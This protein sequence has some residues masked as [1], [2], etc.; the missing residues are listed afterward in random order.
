MPQKME[1]SILATVDKIFDDA[2]SLCH[3]E[4][5]LKERIKACNLT[6]TIRF[7]VRLRGKV[8]SFNGWR[9]VHS[10]HQ[11]PA[12]GGIRYAPNV[13]QDEVEGLAALMTYKCALMGIPFSGSKG[14]LQ[15]DRTEW[16]P[17]ELERITR[18]FTQELAKRNLIGPSQNVPA[19]DM[20]T[21]ETEMAWIADEYQRLNRLDINAAACVTGKPLTHGGIEGRVEATGRGTQYAVQAFFRSWQDRGP[22][23]LEGPLKGK[24]VIIQ[25]LGNVGYHA[26]KFLSEE[27]GCIITGVIERDGS[28]YCAEGLDIEKLY[29]H[30]KKNG[31]VKDFP[32]TTF[33]ADGA[34]LLEAPCDILIPAALENVITS[35]NAADIQAKL[36]VEAANGPISHEGNEI[37]RA[38]GIPILPDIYVNSG[39]VTVSYFEWIKNLGHMQLGLLDHQRQENQNR[40]IAEM[41]ES[42]TGAKIPQDQWDS[43]VRGS[44]EIDLV[45]SGLGEMMRKA[46][47]RMLAIY[48]T[49]DGVPD[50]RTAAYILAIETVAK[51]YQVSGI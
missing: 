45:R 6:L 35:A 32:G 27:D 37:L 26:A 31:G 43:F 18:R 1:H 2:S 5:G 15:I 3:L 13:D 17:H 23:G 36:I 49:R 14:A 39:G 30:M 25:G 8:I 24:S 19:P 44:D 10:E 22:L 48:Q 28:L 21:S 46:F 41:L 11:H 9:S 47:E 34:K 12:K 16:E 40:R 51:S 7:G 29:Q 33:N 38:R 20:G 50:L 42:M 4:D